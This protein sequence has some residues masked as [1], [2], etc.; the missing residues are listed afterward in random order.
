MYKIVDTRNGKVVRERFKAKVDAKECIETNKK[1][2]EDS[3]HL[4]IL[5]YVD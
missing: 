1:L 2:F 5:R 3:I 4:R